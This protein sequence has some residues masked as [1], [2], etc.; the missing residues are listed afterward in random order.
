MSGTRSGRAAVWYETTR[1][2]SK[3]SMR[4]TGHPACSRLKF[5]VESRQTFRKTDSASHAH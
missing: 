1:W 4:L 5:S 2:E 3:P